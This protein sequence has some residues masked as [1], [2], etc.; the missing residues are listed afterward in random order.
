MLINNI[1]NRL[2]KADIKLQKF[3]TIFNSKYRFI[4]TV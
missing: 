2:T 3:G 4:G 1:F